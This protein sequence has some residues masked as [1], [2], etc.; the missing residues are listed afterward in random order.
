[1]QDKSSDESEQNSFE[2]DC[3]ESESDITDSG[4]QVTDDDDQPAVQLFLLRL[5]TWPSR[6][7]QVD[8]L[9]QGTL[10]GGGNWSGARARKNI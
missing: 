1:V 9:Y 5:L 4:W 2:A 7:E 10:T 6:N 8:F 3:D